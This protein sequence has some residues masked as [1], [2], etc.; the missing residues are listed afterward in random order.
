METVVRTEV[1]LQ[2]FSDEYSFRLSEKTIRTYVRAMEQLIKYSNKP[3]GEISTKD[4]RR[5]LNHLNES[6]YKVNTINSKLFGVKLFYRYCLEEGV[7]THDPIKS[8]SFPA[9]EISLPRYLRS[10]QW[11]QLTNHV[12]GKLQERAV[13]EVLHA[14]GVRIG[15]LTAMKKE[16]INWTERIIHIQKGKRKKGRIVL[17]T[18]TCSEHLKA[19]LNE[20][21]DD[22]PYVFVN[23]KGNGPA[24]IRTIQKKFSTYQQ[25]LGIKVSP[26]VLR[27]TFAA[28]LAIKG[29][30]LEAIQMLLGHESPH[31]TQLYARLY[32]HARKQMYDEWM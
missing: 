4:I 9:R 20:R 5:W 32:D 6:G 19:Y 16:N 22:L 28:N 10:D 30:P 27:H 12:K 17:F 15:E 26:H 24:C 29:M 8:I 14:T 21:C 23:T 3:F 31:Q 13:V 7:I 2:K 1:W 18:K 25:P 11:V